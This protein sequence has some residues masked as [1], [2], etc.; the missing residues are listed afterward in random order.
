MREVR[1]YGYRMDMESKEL[2]EE[3]VGLKIFGF[4]YQMLVVLLRYQRRG[5]VDLEVRIQFGIG[6]RN[7]NYLDR[8]DYQVVGLKDQS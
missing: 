2:Q 4:V 7:I 8:N 6:V 3:K 5:G 1:V